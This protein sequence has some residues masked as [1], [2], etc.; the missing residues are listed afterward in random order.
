MVGAHAQ[1][2][3]PPPPPSPSCAHSLCACA[4][5]TR[6]TCALRVR[7]RRQCPFVPGFTGARL[8]AHVSPSS[9]A[10]SHSPRAAPAARSRR[11]RWSSRMRAR[12]LLTPH[13]PSPVG[14]LHTRV[15]WRAR[16]AR[17]HHFLRAR[18]SARARD[19][20]CASRRRCW[21]MRARRFIDTTCPVPGRPS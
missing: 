21:P 13:V 1:V 11:R 18:L 10:R 15:V 8:C 4:R 3:R 17:T 16:R 12:R 2:R 14:R 9:R 20:P 19:P 5:A 7:A 6:A